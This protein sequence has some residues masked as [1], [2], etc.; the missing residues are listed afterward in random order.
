MTEKDVGKEC[1]YLCTEVQ[2]SKPLATCVWILGTHSWVR[3]VGI[4]G[5]LRLLNIHISLPSLLYDYGFFIFLF[6]WFLR[7]GL[8]TK[9]RLALNSQ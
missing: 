1:T 9:P 3:H 4:L 7:W 6:F 8:A 5:E 2:L